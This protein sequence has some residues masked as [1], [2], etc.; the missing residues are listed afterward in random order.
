MSELKTSEK[1]QSEI[2][3]GT[4]VYDPDGWDR[5]NFQYSWYEEEITHA[6]Y[7]NRKMRSSIIGYGKVETYG[8]K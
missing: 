7:L 2:K 5:T 8:N 1:W 3:D 6:E 4:T